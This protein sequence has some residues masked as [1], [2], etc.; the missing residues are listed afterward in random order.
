MCFFAK[1]GVSR[2]GFMRTWGLV[3]GLTAAIGVATHGY[4]CDDNS[5]KNIVV[6]AANE[7]GGA[8]QGN[9][10]DG[11]WK[12]II[13]GENEKCP[14]TVNT[15]FKV[16]NGRLIQQYSGGVVRPNGSATGTAAG[17]GFTATWTGRFSGN[18]ASGRF[19]RSDG[20]VGRW[21]A[22]RQ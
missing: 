4:A 6:A 14:R 15:A 16:E 8:Q 2:S 19:K 22:V 18:N 11:D 9:P 20:C 13:T 7:A 12:E 3:V 10:F 1:S 21:E 17:G 5:C